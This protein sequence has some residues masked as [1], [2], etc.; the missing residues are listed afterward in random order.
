MKA[1]E[2]FKKGLYNQLCMERERGATTVTLMCDGKTATF[3]FTGDG[4]DVMTIFSDDDLPHD[5]GKRLKE[6][7]E[8]RLAGEK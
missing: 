2:A 4:I 3:K 8:Q 5:W 6:A 1:S 7:R